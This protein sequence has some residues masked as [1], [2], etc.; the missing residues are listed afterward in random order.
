MDH[1]D[2]YA[3]AQGGVVLFH[4]EQ[5]EGVTTLGQVENIG[6]GYAKAGNGILY[7][8]KPLPGG[9]DGSIV[10]GFEDLGDGWARTGGGRGNGRY[11]Y[12]GSEKK[13]NDARACP[14]W[15]DGKP[16]SGP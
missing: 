3:S 14:A 16:Q 8:G 4:G 2:G 15:H 5:V 6:G 12:R 7:M 10:G 1:G 13:D 9:P 11:F